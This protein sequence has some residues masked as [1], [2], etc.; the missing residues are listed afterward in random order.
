[1]TTV[2]ESHSLFEI[3]H[4]LDD[5]LEQ[6]EEQ[7]EAEGEASEEL[8]C[9][10][11]QFCEVHGE[12]VDRIGRF[13]RMMEA[14][15]QYCRAEAARL[16]DRA[17]ATANKVDRTKSMVLFYLMSRELRK[18]EGREFTLRI[19]K[20]S[21]D[22]VRILDEV[23]LPMSYRKVEARIG[24]VLWETVLSYLPEDLE[25]ALAACIHETK[26]DTEAIKIA[27]SRDEKVAGAEIRRGFHLRVA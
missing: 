27:V 6:I 12:K 20:N 14:R 24:G 11:R 4:E 25:R 16:G 10:F 1:M 22:S 7:V 3:D 21:Q 18:I 2:V 17:R 19:Q 26:P 9:R 5:L 8:L 15:E 23:S 13:V